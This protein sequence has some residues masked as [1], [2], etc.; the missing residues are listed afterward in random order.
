MR[1]AQVIASAVVL[2]VLAALPL[3]SWA[4]KSK[5][6]HDCLVEKGGKYV[7]VKGPLAGKTYGSK[8]A[9]MEALRS[10]V[11]SGARQAEVRP[12][13]E[14]PAKKAGKKP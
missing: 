7:C 2:V 9:M 12:R 10:G 1:M 5:D 6:K 4:A 14:R 3:A 8:K 13:N 11:S